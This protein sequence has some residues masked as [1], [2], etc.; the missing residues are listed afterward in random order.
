MERTPVTSSQINSIGYDPNSRVL[1]VEFNNNRVYQYH[2]VT[3]ECHLELMN[4][5]SKGKY[6][7]A[8]IKNNELITTTKL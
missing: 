8:N 4:A 7:N 6:F 1:E 2:P 5:E 3:E